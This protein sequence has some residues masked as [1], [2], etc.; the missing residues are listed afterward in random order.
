MDEEQKNIASLESGVHNGSDVAAVGS[1]DTAFVLSGLNLGL[2]M[3]GLGL[4]VF[5]MAIDTSI[6]A[7]AIPSITSQFG[8][9]ADIGWYGSAYSFALC[10][11]QPIAG[12][13]YASFS[14]KVFGLLKV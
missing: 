8:S 13:L 11:L 12:K 14:H 3:L 10:A 7:T 4:G 9:T 6:L 1:S 5:L 2:V